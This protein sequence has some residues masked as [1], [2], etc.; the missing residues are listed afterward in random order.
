M[1]ESII[2]PQ[3]QRCGNC[4]YWK[5]VTGDKGECRVVVHIPWP[6]V[7]QEEWCGQWMRPYASSEKYPGGQAPGLE[8]W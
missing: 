5:S 1:M 3:D 4:R 2:S 8:P 6:L 7:G